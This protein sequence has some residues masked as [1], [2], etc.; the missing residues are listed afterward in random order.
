M[1]I[2]P[3]PIIVNQRKE[4]GRGIVRGYYVVMVIFTAR[5]LA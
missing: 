4:N 3:E 1:N 5:K 2:L